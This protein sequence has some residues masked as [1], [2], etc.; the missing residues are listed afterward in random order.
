MRKQDEKVDSEKERDF[1]KKKNRSFYFFV[2]YLRY[3][4][5]PIHGVIDRLKKSFKLSWLRVRLSYH[6]FNNLAELLNELIVT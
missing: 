3:F 4:S 5:K 1:T 2:A 6:I